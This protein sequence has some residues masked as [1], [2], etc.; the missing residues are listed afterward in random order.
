MTCGSAI[1]RAKAA[2]SAG[3]PCSKENAAARSQRSLKSNARVHLAFRQQHLRQLRLRLVGVGQ[4]RESAGDHRQRLGRDGADR[5]RRVLA[6]T[7]ER[8]VGVGVVER[9][10]RGHQPGLPVV[11]TGVRVL[12]RDLRGPERLFDIAASHGRLRVE[13]DQLVA[14]RRAERA[15]RR[16]LHRRL[17]GV[18]GLLVRAP[19]VQH[20]SRREGRLDRRIGGRGAEGP[21]RRPRVTC[22]QRQDRQADQR[23]AH[24]RA[25]PLSAAPSLPNHD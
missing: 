20:A 25:P 10:G 3:W 6:E 16:R 24:P 22:G 21:L 11:G 9:G 13:G 19:G 17:K 4:H 15:H 14:A 1:R 12:G 2:A 8:G 18:L 7:I 5:G 23:F